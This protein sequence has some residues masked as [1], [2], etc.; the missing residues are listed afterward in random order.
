[1]VAGKLDQ[2]TRCFSSSKANRTLARCFSSS[3]DRN[4]LAALTIRAV[5]VRAWTAFADRHVNVNTARLRTLLVDDA[6]MT[7]SPLVLSVPSSG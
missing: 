1:M 3:V 7:A 4:A 6:A 5:V 2:R